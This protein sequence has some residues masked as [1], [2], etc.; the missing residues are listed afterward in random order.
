MEWYIGMEVVALKT[1][2]E[3][4]IKKGQVFTICGLRSPKCKCNV[5][6]LDIGIIEDDGFQYC[7]VCNTKDIVTNGIAW[8]DERDFVPLEYDRQAI[9]ELIQLT[10]QKEQTIK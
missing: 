10:K 3:Y 5:I 2:E 6:D 1:F 4:K 9:E 8:Q 7:D